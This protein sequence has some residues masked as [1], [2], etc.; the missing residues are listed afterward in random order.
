MCA[1]G[2]AGVVKAVVKAKLLRQQ[3]SL[4]SYRR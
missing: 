2:L 1:T 3:I 4:M